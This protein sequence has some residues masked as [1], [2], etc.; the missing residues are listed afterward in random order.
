M[1]VEWLSAYVSSPQSTICIYISLIRLQSMDMFII[2]PNAG[3]VGDIGEIFSFTLQAPF[4]S[5]IGQSKIS[6]VSS[7]EGNDPKE[8]SLGQFDIFRV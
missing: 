6:S 5:M 4:F 3:D 2:Y 1:G 7:V 8:R